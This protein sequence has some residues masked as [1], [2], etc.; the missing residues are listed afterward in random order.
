MDFRSDTTTKPT[1]A[2]LEAILT[3]ELGDDVM[4]ECGLVLAAPPARS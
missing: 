3:A 1:R 4:G 2:M